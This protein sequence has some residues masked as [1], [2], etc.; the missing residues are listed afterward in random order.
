V[1][2]I[3]T[4]RNNS[5]DLFRLFAAILIVMSHSKIFIETND[6]IYYMITEFMPRF[7]VPF[8][9]CTSGY[10]MIKALLQDKKIIKKVLKNLLIIYTIWSLIYYIASYIDNVILSNESIKQFMIERVIYFFTRGSYAHFWYFTALIYTIIIVA[11]VIK[12]WGEKGIK[13]LAIISLFLNILGALGTAYYNIG[14]NIPILTT[15]Y[16]W[17]NFDVLRNIICMGLAYFSL[18]YFIILLENKIYK[19]SIKK[20]NFILIISVLIY[21]LEI[22]LLVIILKWTKHIE[23]MFST[24]FITGIIFIKLLRHPLDKAKNIAIF[25]RKIANFIYYLHPLLLMG[26]PFVFKGIGI[27]YNNVVLFICVVLILFIIGSI[28]I[29]W[30]SKV[31][32]ILLGEVWSKGRKVK[33]EIDAK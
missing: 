28:L 22:V 7:T 8:F 2:E 18:G 31:G 19:I 29:K 20:I 11:I 3:K 26:I 32:N 25:S 14:T 13:W 27:R 16:N 6:N 24:Y 30:N 12:L 23:L 17:E 9:F 21:L 5:I 4:K 10:F 15:I 1:E 33:D